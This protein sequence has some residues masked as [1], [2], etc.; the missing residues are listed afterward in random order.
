M[1]RKPRYVFCL[2]TKCIVCSKAL[3]TPF[4]PAKLM[5]LQYSWKPTFNTMAGSSANHH[6]NEKNFLV[7]FILGG[8]DVSTW[9]L[10]Y[11][12]SASIF[13]ESCCCCWSAHLEW[14]NCWN[15]R[16]H[17]TILNEITNV[18]RNSRSR[19]WC[20][21]RKLSTVVC[22]VVFVLPLRN[23][24][25]TACEGFGYWCQCRHFCSSCHARPAHCLHHR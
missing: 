12:Y 3:P 4:K 9:N 15:L 1:D 24:E 5:K 17:V 11:L 10:Y 16:A 23:L 19:W 14:W 18:C 2:K 7:R 21:N 13:S 6:K 22:W 25:P 8:T 20:E